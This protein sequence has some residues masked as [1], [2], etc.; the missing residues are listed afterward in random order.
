MQKISIWGCDRS[1]AMADAP[2]RVTRRRLTVFVVTC[3]VGAAALVAVRAAPLSA[4][5]TVRLAALGDD[6]RA[7]DDDDSLLADM[8]VT[9]IEVIDANGT[10]KVVAL[11]R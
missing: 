10:A 4:Q 7:A 5:K 8:N 3:V 9:E 1:H 6:E 11:R 2:A